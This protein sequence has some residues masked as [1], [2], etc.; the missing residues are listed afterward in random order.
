MKC[1]RALIALLAMGVIPSSA[2]AQSPFVPG[3]SVSSSS[4]GAPMA[5]WQRI[6]PNGSTVGSVSL[7]PSEPGFSASI[8]ANQAIGHGKWLLDGALDASS[9]GTLS[10]RSGHIGL[11]IN[12]P[13]SRP[14]LLQAS[15]GAGFADGN[16]VMLDSGLWPE[17]K[18]QQSAVS[19]GL[20]WAASPLTSLHITTSLLKAG[21]PMPDQEIGLNSA[22]TPALYLSVGLHDQQHAGG[23]TLAMAAMRWQPRSQSALAI[24]LESDWANG[25]WHEPSFDDAQALGADAA[26]STRSSG[27]RVFAALDTPLSPALSLRLGASF[28]IHGHAGAP[29]DLGPE[30]LASLGHGL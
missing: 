7:A 16:S 4:F 20:R 2:H 18:R 27:Q 25:Y 11:A 8:A 23:G 22:L 30:F 19:A 10:S 6:G 5:M 14:G 12:I 9:A 28:A 24:S 15:L 21:F 29:S 17:P 13:G 3:F 1:F 26:L